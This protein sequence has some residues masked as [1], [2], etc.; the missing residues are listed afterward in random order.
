MTA[1]CPQVAQGLRALYEGENVSN[2]KGKLP[3]INFPP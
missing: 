3:T 1:V 2:L